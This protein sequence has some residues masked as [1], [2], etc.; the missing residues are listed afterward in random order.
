MSKNMLMMLLR[1]TCSIVDAS[2][3]RDGVQVESKDL[4]VHYERVGEDHIVRGQSSSD[5]EVNSTTP[6]LVNNTANDEV[7]Q[8]IV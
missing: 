3:Q 2:D 4:Q 5:S 8:A 1:V 6:L 7:L